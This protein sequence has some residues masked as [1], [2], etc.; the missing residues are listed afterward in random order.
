M[1][2]AVFKFVA[3]RV[4]RAARRGAG[5][6]HVK[7]VEAHA[8]GAERVEVRGFEDRI[9]V[10]G[11]VA[12]ALIIGENKNDIGPRRGGGRCGGKQGRTGQK[13]QRTGALK[14]DDETNER[15]NRGE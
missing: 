3:P 12:V 13:K 4:E 1:G 6:T 8:L 9:A 15:H 14:Q 10:G 5:G 7:I 11:K 2:D